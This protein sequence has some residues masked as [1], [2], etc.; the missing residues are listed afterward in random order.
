[1]DKARDTSAAGQPPGVRETA[2]RL[3][4]QA[5][6]EAG[7]R[8]LAAAGAPGLSLRAIARELGMASSAIYRY[9][10]SADELLTELIIR[11]YSDLARAA[12]Q[13]AASTEGAEERF[14]AACH[15]CR[16]WALEQPHRYALIYGSPVPAYSAPSATIEPGARVGMLLLGVVGGAVQ[17]GS[18]AE[19]GALGTGVATDGL[20]DP[21]AARLAEEAGLPPVLLPEAVDTWAHLFGLISFELFG[22][23]TNVVADRRGC[24]DRMMRLRCRS[25]L[26]AAGNPR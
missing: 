6:V 5:I 4:V 18:G 23:F 25:L 17:A 22:H 11:A 1:M 19:D 2:R 24:F 10:G 14:M 15:A 26:V 13:A 9:F 3:Q 12:E 21:G 20:M 7:E 16:T 8:Q